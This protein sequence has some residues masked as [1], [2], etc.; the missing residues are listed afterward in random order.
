M[1]SP[2]GTGTPTR[3]GSTAVAAPV[4]R[5][6][7]SR[8]ADALALQGRLNSRAA[9]LLAGQEQGWLAALAD[10]ASA[11]GRQQ[12]LLFSR[13]REV[14][15]TSFGYTV[16]GE[17]AT[18]Q[19][20]SLRPGQW[21]ADV[22]LSYRMPGDARDVARPTSLIVTGTPDGPKVVGESPQPTGSSPP[23]RDLWEL[24]DVT[25]VR[26]RNSIVVGDAS[27][28]RTLRR[29]AALTDRAVRTVDRYWGG[30]WRRP[31]VVVVPESV[32][33]MAQVLGRGGT[34]GLDQLAAVTTGEIDRVGG[35][36]APVNTAD[37]VV[38]NPD[39][40]DSFADDRNRQI[41]L[42]HEMTHVATRGTVLVSPPLWLE[43][44][45][46]DFVGYQDS[47][48]SR[49]TIAADLL[50]EV[51]RGRGPDRLP[52][53]D[54]FDPGKGKVDD[55]YVASWLALTMIEETRGASGVVAFYRTAAGL[56]EAPPAG[57]ATQE[58]CLARAYARLGTDAEGFRRQWLAYL[59]RIAG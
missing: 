2:N 28:P 36:A 21:V 6:A 20:A 30:G 13:L 17:S 7:R 25:V 11:Y 47:G 29:Y 41:V 45:F 14:P 3:P 54:A 22:R 5:Q 58:A 48:V 37:R 19:T 26:G 32:D 9:A 12:R 35:V 23:M 39:A 31:V 42:T 8:A 44:A 46:A 38:I 16:V 43:E 57:E 33:Q 4:P 49:A 50:A 10:P 59:E 56:E 27:S 24:T 18:G 1:G 55:A 40:F 15:F 51:R 34:T 52:T 53:Q